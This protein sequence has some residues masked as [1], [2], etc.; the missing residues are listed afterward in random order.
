MR[1]GIVACS[2]LGA[3]LDRKAASAAVGVRRWWQ[4]Q[5]PKPNRRRLRDRRRRTPSTPDDDRVI[6][7]G[8]GRVPPGCLGAPLSMSHRIAREGKECRIHDR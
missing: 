7:R 3:A 6:G 1:H 5:R 8:F 2:G 4:P